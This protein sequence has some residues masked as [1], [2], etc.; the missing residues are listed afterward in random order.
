M[1][2]KFNMFEIL[3]KDDKEIVHS[4][5]IGR[6]IKKNSIDFSILEKLFKINYFGQII[7]AEVQTECQ[8]GGRKRIDLK[9]RKEKENVSDT[10]LIPDKAKKNKKMSEID[11]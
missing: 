10:I 3:S 4:A 2:E 11:F 7:D 1:I 8:L 6:L 5:V 9:K